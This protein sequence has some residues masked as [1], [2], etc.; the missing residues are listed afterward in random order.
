[1][2]TSMVNKIIGL[3]ILGILLNHF[4]FMVFSRTIYFGAME[5]W[6]IGAMARRLMSFFQHANTP[7][8]Q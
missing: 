7:V 3:T 4:D 8:R 5:R 2:I 6:S 1:M